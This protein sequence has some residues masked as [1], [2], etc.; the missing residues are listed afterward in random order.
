MGRDPP[1]C[2]QE[3]VV[4]RFF[5]LTPHVKGFCWPTRMLFRFV[6]FS[7]RQW[8]AVLTVSPCT[9]CKYCQKRRLDDIIF[10]LLTFPIFLIID[11]PF[12]MSSDMTYSLLYN[13]TG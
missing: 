3:L 7:V 8:P 2:L 12:R 10:I 13:D 6:G 5:M 11:W 1:S 9:V 4:R